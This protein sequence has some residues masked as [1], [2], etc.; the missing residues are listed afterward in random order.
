MNKKYCDI[1]KKELV[2]EFEQEVHLCEDCLNESQLTDEELMIN[3]EVYYNE[4]YP[5]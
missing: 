3:E 4:D 5:L 2:T 1:C